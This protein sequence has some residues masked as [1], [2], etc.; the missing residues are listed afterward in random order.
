M[1]E[2]VRGPGHTP[3][4]RTHAKIDTPVK[5]LPALETG[6]NPQNSHCKCNGG[7]RDTLGGDF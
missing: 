2:S 3:Q 1:S 6:E 7:P 5:P 4:K